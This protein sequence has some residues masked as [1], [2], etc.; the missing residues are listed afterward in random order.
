MAGVV[1]APPIA[2]VGRAPKKKFAT[3]P[4]KIACL[5]W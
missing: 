5:A 4:V 3:P 2:D 1:T